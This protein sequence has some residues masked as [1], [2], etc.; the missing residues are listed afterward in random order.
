MGFQDSNTT[1]QHRLQYGGFAS[2]TRC[3]L[4]P[5]IECLGARGLTHR[6]SPLICGCNT[7]GSNSGQSKQRQF[8]R[9]TGVLSERG[10]GR[11][12]RVRRLCS[13]RQSSPCLLLQPGAHDSLSVRA[14]TETRHTRL[15]ERPP[16]APRHASQRGR[17]RG[18]ISFAQTQRQQ[19]M[20]T[21]ARNYLTTS[22]AVGPKETAPDQP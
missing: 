20:R 15:S 14:T 19:G 12:K 6:P 11:G 9:N 10:L 5:L 21:S 8:H 22:D 16:H 13:S 17:N 7:R 4:F 1:F 3:C 18:V 2:T